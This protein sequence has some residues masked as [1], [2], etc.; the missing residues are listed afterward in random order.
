MMNQ[1]FINIPNCKFKMYKYREVIH[2]ADWKM[3]EEKIENAKNVYNAIKNRRAIR[4]VKPEMVPDEYL[5]K[6]IEA[7]SY[8]PSPENYEPWRFIIV[9]DKEILKVM[10]ERAIKGCV[11]MFG[12]QLPRTEIAHRFGYM[13]KA[14]PI[15]LSTSLM[16]SGWRMCYIRDAPVQIVVCADT[17]RI[18]AKDI[19]PIVITSAT[20]LAQRLSYVCAGLSLMNAHLMS[21][22]LGLG[23]CIHNFEYQDPSDHREIK[24]LLDL[25]GPHWEIAAS[26]SVGIPIRERELGPPRASPE[27]LAFDNKWGNYWKPKNKLDW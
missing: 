16:A 18:M 21:H 20:H 4:D 8:A 2:L 26:L 17:K 12:V 15:A 14:R 19:S 3:L 24:E 25:P 13:V 10:G 6:I 23:S 22:A 1:I 9:R 27:E 7:A 5:Y 11:T